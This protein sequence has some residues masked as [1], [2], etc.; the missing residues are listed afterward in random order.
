MPEMQNEPRAFTDLS[1]QIPF[2]GNDDFDRLSEKRDDAA[3]VASLRAEPNARSLVFVGDVPV[4]R[5]AGLRIDPWF[6]LAEVEDFGSLRETVLL[7]RDKEG[8]RFA[9]L[10]D[11]SVARVVG[12]LDPGA[13]V[14]RRPRMIPNRP[15][16]TLT[17]LRSLAVGGGLSSACLGM[18]AQAK[19]ILYWHM[20]HRFCSVCGVPTRMSSA[21]WRR[22][23]PSCKGMHFPRTD[24]VVIML[25]VDGDECLMGRSGRFGKG[26]YSA[27]AGF[28]EPGETL[29]SAV[30][31]E[32]REESGILTGK[33]TY[34][35][36]QP[37]PFPASLMLGCFAQALTRKLVIDRTEL[38]DARWFSR[39]EVRHMMAG[40]HPLGFTAP[41]PV[42]IA[43]HLL[44]AWVEAVG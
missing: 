42:A 4:L 11:E 36:S 44:K 23:C 20:R 25:A 1:A 37:W 41:Q 28:L 6:A 7:G 30:R 43:H 21:G 12:V 40:T 13:R 34:L 29:E 18:M 27:L 31:R 24:P 39:S 38:E 22:D 9:V 33:V 5:Q 35:A 10:L 19:S 26:M 2:S 17:D 16:Y 32:I 15:E 14:D 3:F 8:P